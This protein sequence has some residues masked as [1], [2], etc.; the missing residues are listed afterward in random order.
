MPESLLVTQQRCEPLTSLQR[1]ETGATCD[2]CESLGILSR[3]KQRLSETSF[4]LCARPARGLSKGLCRSE[5]PRRFGLTNP[6]FESRTYQPTRPRMRGRF[7]CC[8]SILG[9]SK[10][11]RLPHYLSLATLATKHNDR[12]DDHPNYGQDNAKSG[13][14][15]LFLPLFIPEAW[16]EF[17]H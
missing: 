9:T 17:L 6:S 13:L 3:G 1:F 12:N 8:D 15:H 7:A 14:V 16:K 5:N 4:Q 2:R 10:T 11:P